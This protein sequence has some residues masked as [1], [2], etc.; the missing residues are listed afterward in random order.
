MPQRSGNTLTRST[1]CDM[2]CGKFLAVLDDDDWWEPEKLAAQ[3]AAFQAVPNAAWSYHAAL[4]VSPAGPGDIERVNH[5]KDFLARLVQY[6]WLRHSSMMFRRSAFEAIGGYDR[7]LPLASDWDLVLRLTLRFGE[8]AIAVWPE[9]LVNYWVHPA[10]ISTNT[11]LRITAERR[12]VRRAL[13]QEGLWRRPGL[14]LRMIDRQ[15][16]RE[17]Y[18]ALSAGH[19]GRGCAASLLSAMAR[20][21]RLWRWRRAAAFAASIL[22]R[23]RPGS[24]APNVIPAQGPAP[25]PVRVAAVAP[26]PASP[27]TPCLQPA[28]AAAPAP[29]PNRLVHSGA[30][31]VMAEG[32][33]STVD[34]A[35]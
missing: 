5:G 14:A 23:R 28:L 13:V 31:S 20:P 18:G 1:A 21:F 35:S 11:P 22:T 24:Q 34:G 26:V 7:L 33:L 19:Y 30:S 16:D 2:A 3:I 25:A 27:R 6:N 4:L 17:M 10:N 29:P 8:D 12:V 32:V 15:L 9:A